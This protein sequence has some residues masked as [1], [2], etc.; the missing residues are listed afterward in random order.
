MAGKRDFMWWRSE[1]ARL[2]ALRQAQ[3]TRRAELEAELAELD[4]RRGAAAIAALD[5]GEA[6]REVLTPCSEP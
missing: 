3:E 6:E 5:G 2:D 4:A 1:I